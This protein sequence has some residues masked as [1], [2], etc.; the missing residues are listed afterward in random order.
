MYIK[1]VALSLSLS[2]KTTVTQVKRVVNTDGAEFIDP[3][4][5]ANVFITFFVGVGATLASKFSSDTS[6]INPPVSPETFLFQN[7]QQKTV[8]D[9]ISGF[10]NG[11]AIYRTGWNWYEIAQG[12][13][14]CSEH[15]SHID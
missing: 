8:E 9:N 11:K 7:I 6:Q 14:S 3:K 4:S 10:K 12:R 15:F 5:I 1:C 13:F 2:R